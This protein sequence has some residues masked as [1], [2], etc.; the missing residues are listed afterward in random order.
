MFGGHWYSKIWSLLASYRFIYLT[1]TK[2]L[3]LFFCVF[4]LF[5]ALYFSLLNLHLTWQKC[6]CLWKYFVF[7]FEHTQ[8]PPGF[9]NKCKFAS[10]PRKVLNNYS[11][12]NLSKISQKTKWI[13]QHS[14][15][16]FVVIIFIRMVTPEFTIWIKIA[17]DLRISQLKIVSFFLSPCF[18][19]Y[20]EASCSVILL[21][22]RLIFVFFLNWQILNWS[23]SC[24]FSFDC[25]DIFFSFYPKERT[26]WFLIQNDLFPNG[27]LVHYNIIFSK[28]YENVLFNVLLPKCLSD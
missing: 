27:L 14:Y 5:V 19:Y 13:F 3:P 6:F 16:S 7:V 25:L 1:I 20:L 26:W 15:K 24:Y 9:N 2:A 12:P 10:Y 11:T 21:K 22:L 28:Y 18:T 17:L 23:V 4:G 8:T